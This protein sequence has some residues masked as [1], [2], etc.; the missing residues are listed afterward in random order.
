MLVREGGIYLLP[1]QEA[2]QNYLRELMM[3]K[4]KL[5]KSE[6]ILAIKVLQYKGLTVK[7]I[8]EFA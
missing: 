6:N 7:S 3:G 8:I 2:T 1:N 5:I 4:K